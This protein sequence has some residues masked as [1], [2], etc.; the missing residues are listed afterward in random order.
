MLQAESSGH[1]KAI[2]KREQLVAIWNSDRLKTQ[3]KPHVTIEDRLY[4]LKVKE[5]WD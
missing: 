4:H 5:Q 1:T 2:N 3:M